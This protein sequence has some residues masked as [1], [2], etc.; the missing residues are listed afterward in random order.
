MVLGVVMLSA[1]SMLDFVTPKSSWYAG[2]PMTAAAVSA[3]IGFMAAGICLDGWMK[4][5]EARRLDRISTVAYRSLAQFANDAGRTL[6]APLTGADLY[7][8][9]IPEAGPYDDE[10][11]LAR[12]HSAGHEPR[13]SEATG[14]WRT[15]D[16]ATLDRA[17]QD[18]LDD[19]DFVRLLFRKTAVM[20]RRLQEVTATWA[21]VM[22]TSRQYAEDL[23]RLRELT[24]ALEM[25][26]EQLRLSRVVGHSVLAPWVALDGWKYD[27]AQA[28]WSAIDS[29]ERLR[30]D[31]GDLAALPSDSILRRRTTTPTQPPRRSRTRRAAPTMDPMKAG[32]R[33]KKRLTGV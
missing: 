11:N 5:R 17:L 13:F 30:D 27:V 10:V 24:D 23:G 2:H 25:L 32:P 16:R 14:S 6:L 15:E 18:L 29:Y 8:L 22:L 28:Y 21:P 7:A 19:V 9:G 4:D 12:L 33:S 31:F 1:L 26:Q 3:L 20:R